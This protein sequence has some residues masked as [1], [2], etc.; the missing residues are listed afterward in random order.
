[1]C[2]ELLRHMYG[3]RPAADGWQE[4]C[5]TL[6]VR[7][8]FAQGRGSAN[9]FWHA[10]RKISCSIHAGDFT[11]TGPADALDWYEDAIASEYEIAVGPRLGP[12]LE[13]AKEP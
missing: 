7:L 6:L 11:A 4:E 9:V 1:M 3:T 13:D 12:G 10:L 5:S 2:G 8:G